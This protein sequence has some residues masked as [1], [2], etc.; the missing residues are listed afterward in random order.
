MLCF[1]HIITGIVFCGFYNHAIKSF[2]SIY[3]AK[4]SANFILHVYMSRAFIRACVEISFKLENIWYRLSVKFRSP[5]DQRVQFWYLLTSSVSESSCH[6]S[7][8]F[9]ALPIFYWN[10]AHEI[11]IKVLHKKVTFTLFPTFKMKHLHVRWRV[12]FCRRKFLV[13]AMFML[14]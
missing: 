9:V 5:K 11:T 12:Q 8:K 13:L 7:F 1:I 3:V 6:F 2:S 14:K 10:T 4:C